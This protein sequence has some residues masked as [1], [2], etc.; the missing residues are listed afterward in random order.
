MEA[1]LRHLENVKAQLKAEEEMHVAQAK[2]RVLRDIQPKYA[3]IEQIK[4]EEL[5]SLQKDYATNRNAITEQY[6][7]QLAVLQQNFDKKN[8]EIVELAQKRKE[9]LYETTLHKETCLIKKEFEDAIID[10]DELIAERTEK[11]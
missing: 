1:V 9:E 5:N 7:V 6:N 11:E 8:K 4:A 10:I 3:E 2:E